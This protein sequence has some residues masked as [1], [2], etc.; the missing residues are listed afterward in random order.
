MRRPAPLEPALGRG[1]STVSRTRSRRSSTRGIH[2]R[3]ADVQGAVVGKKVA[4]W[5]YRHAFQPVG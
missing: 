5:L 1:N 4:H 2:F 3:T